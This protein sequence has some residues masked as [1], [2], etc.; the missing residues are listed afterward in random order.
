M[1]NTHAGV[2]FAGSSN[3]FCGHTLCLQTQR[4]RPWIQH[5]F[6][7]TLTLDAPEMVTT[8]CAASLEAPATCVIVLGDG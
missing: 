7:F 2:S 8:T 5:T 4:V 6:I 3:E 1:N